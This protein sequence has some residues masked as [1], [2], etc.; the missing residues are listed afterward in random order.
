[1]LDGDFEIAALA[2]FTSRELDQVDAGHRRIE[3]PGRLDRNEL[4]E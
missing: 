1:M 2:L 3:P 4:G